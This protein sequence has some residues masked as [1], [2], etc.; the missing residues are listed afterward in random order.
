VAINYKT[1]GG[2]SFPDTA[3]VLDIERGQLAVKRDLFWQ[4]DTSVSKTSWGY[5]TNHEYRTVN[6]LIDDLIDI[7]SKNGCMLLNI[8]PRPDGTI[9]PQEQSMLLQ[10]G[11][12]LEI[13]GEGIYDTR[14]WKVFGEGPTKVIEGTFAERKR[15][16]FGAQD[17]RFTCSKD[18]KTLYAIVLA[19]PK[20]NEVLVKSLAKGAISVSQVSQVN[21]LGHQGRLS[22]T[23]T[24]QG[25][26]V[27]L[28]EE[29]PSNYAFTLKIKSVT[30]F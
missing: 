29:R 22:W 23:Q 21:L 26:V 15:Q 2:E 1:H 9:P 6:S 14:P 12:W 10:M 7:V 3:G 19:W 11:A 18:G 28:P 13:N 17:I 20:R 16:D 25:L 27:R 5:V 8:G 30:E 4:T 24:D